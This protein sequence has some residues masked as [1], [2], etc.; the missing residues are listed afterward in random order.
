LA[1]KKRTSRSRKAKTTGKRGRSLWSLLTSLALLL[2]AWFL[3][4]QGYISPDDVAVLLGQQEDSSPP[5]AAQSSSAPVASDGALEVVF[6][7]PAL[8]YPDVP[9]QRSPPPLEQAILADIDAATASIDAALFEY[10]LESLAAALVRAHERGVTVRLALDRENL[11]DPEEAAWA[12]EIEQAGIPIAW[13][14]TTAFLHSKFLIIDAQLVWTGSWNA[15]VNGTYRNN[16]NMLRVQVPEIVANYQA[17]FGQMFEGQFGSH[18][19]SLA[20]YPVVTLD[21][22]LIENYFSPQDGIEPHILERLNAASQSIR[23]LAFSYTSD[24]IAEAMVARHNA[25]IEVQGV[26]ERRSAGGIGAEFDRLR[27]NG[28]AVLEDGNC[29]T[30][31]HKVIIIDEATVIT[32]SYNFSRRAE[33][34]NDENLLIIDSPELAAQYMQEFDRVYAQAQNPTACGR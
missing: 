31:H 32:G 15:T 25:G 19:E 6:T 10:N 20:P 13:Q 27:D 18:K 11:E 33:E 2:A 1:K 28:I 5:P 8:V 12:G 14:E 16:N 30:M 21:D 9:E 24:P 22:M 26:F 3:V 17:E 29:Y 7:T 34:T 4:Q 23:F